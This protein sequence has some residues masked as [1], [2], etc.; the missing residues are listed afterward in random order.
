MAVFPWLGVHWFDFVQ[1]IGVVGGLLLTSNTIRKDERARQISNLIAINARHDVIWAKL[2]ERP[3]LTRILK[4]HVDLVKDPI[5][6]AERLFVKMLFLHLDTVRRTA[7]AGLFVQLERI[8]ADL[9]CFMKLPIPKAVWE[10]LKTFQDEDF[11]KFV[12]NSIS[13]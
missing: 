5:T 12:E 6:V 9:E 8:R 2:Y 4:Q 11:V 3:E 13:A 1:V 7:A 10:K